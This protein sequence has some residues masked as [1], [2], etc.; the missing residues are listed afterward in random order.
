MAYQDRMPFCPGAPSVELI[1]ALGQANKLLVLIAL[2]LS[3]L[4]QRYGEDKVEQTSINLQLEAHHEVFSE[5]VLSGV[6]PAFSR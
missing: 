3:R 4:K 6:L 2:S 5:E 1:R